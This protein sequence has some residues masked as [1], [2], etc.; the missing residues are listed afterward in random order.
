MRQIKRQT[1]REFECGAQAFLNSEFTGY[2]KGALENSGALIPGFQYEIISI[3]P[4]D[5]DHFGVGKVVGDMLSPATAATA[6]DANNTVKV[7]N[8]DGWDLSAFIRDASNYVVLADANGAI[9]KNTDIPDRIITVGGV[10]LLQTLSDTTEYFLSGK[11]INMTAPAV[12]LA[13]GDLSASLTTDTDGQKTGFLTT[14]IGA[15][16][17]IG[18][19]VASGSVTI[20]F[21]RAWPVVKNA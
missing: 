15:G 9:D 11:L 2:T 18:C 10:I 7:W 19:I 12:T 21:F 16:A 13:L 6:L 14:T 20:Q 3:D 17:I 8:I 5:P 1:G 4:A